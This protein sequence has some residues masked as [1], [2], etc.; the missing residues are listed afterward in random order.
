LP[1]F[2]PKGETTAFGERLFADD[3]VEG[4]DVRENQPQ[5]SSPATSKH[6]YGSTDNE[7]TAMSQM[8]PETATR[9]LKEENR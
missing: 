1:G 5:A 2:L 9:T 3:R 7:C 6:L 4:P 8:R